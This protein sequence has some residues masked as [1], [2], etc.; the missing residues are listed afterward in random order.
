MYVCICR[1]VTDHQI[2]NL[3][4]EGA[5]SMADI[6]NRLG[7]GS[8]CGKCSKLARRIVQEC[9]KTPLFINAADPDG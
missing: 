8:Q 6:R 7:V 1:Q 4:R 5:D 3:C 9:T 2:R